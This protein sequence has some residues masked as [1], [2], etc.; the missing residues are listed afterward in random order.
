MPV[1]SRCSCIHCDKSC[2][3]I[4]NTGEA[5]TIQ[6]LTLMEQALCAYCWKPLQANTNCSRSVWRIAIKFKDLSVNHCGHV[7]HALCINKEAHCRKCNDLIK[8]VSQLHIIDGEISSPN[9]FQESSLLERRL[10]LIEK[11]LEALRL[12]KRWSLVMEWPV[13]FTECR[14]NENK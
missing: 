12:N 9:K 10:S 4:L 5:H 1:D 13:V 6:R 14:N 3:V 8:G 2:H 11:E 7:F